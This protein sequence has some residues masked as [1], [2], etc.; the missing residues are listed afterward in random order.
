MLKITLDKDGKVATVEAEEKTFK[1]GTSGFYFRDR[2]KLN[3]ESYHV[4]V[5]VSK[6]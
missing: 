4:Q 2:V 6:K 3:G 5:I 1:S